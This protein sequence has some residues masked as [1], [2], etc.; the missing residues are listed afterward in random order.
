MH[1]LLLVVDK[2]R[3]SENP[4]IWMTATKA[5]NKYIYIKLYF[6]IIIIIISILRVDIKVKQ[7]LAKPKHSRA[8]APQLGI[9]MFR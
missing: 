5:H 7:R 1:K 8:Q 2:D 3:H 4:N 6:L 9:D